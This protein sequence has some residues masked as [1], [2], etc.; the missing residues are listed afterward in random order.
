ILIQLQSEFTA[1]CSQF[2]THC[3]KSHQTYGNDMWVC[4]LN[5]FGRCEFDNQ[6]TIAQCDQTTLALC[7]QITVRPAS[8]FR[9]FPLAYGDYHAKIVVLITIFGLVKRID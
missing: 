2:S 9:A 6:T 7:E 8:C 1:V 3:T 4:G 5:D